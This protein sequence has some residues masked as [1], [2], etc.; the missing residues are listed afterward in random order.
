MFEATDIREWRGHDVVDTEGHKI[1][2]LE[3]I[4][5]DTSTDRPASATVRVGM[6]TRH[7][8]TFVPLDQAT[9][10]PGHVKVS[11]DRKQVKDAPSIP[12]ASCR[13]ATKRR[14]SGITA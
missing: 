12:T 7:R 14:S 2:E 9:I 6:P 5:V 8:L 3:A 10:G 4:Y 13:P 1:G 11:F